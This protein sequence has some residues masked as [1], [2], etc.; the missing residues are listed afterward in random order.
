MPVQ[1]TI[2]QSVYLHIGHPIEEKQQR[3]KTAKNK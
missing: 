3:V 2:I 1:F